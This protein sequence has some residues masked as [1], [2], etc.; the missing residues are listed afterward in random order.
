MLKINSLKAKSQ[1]SKK[2]IVTNV[3]I[4]ITERCSLKC[5][6]CSNLMQ[7]YHRPQNS[8]RDLL[9]KSVDK[10]MKCIDSLY[11]F[12]VLG[13]DPFMNKKMYEFVNKLAS[14]KNVHQV[15]IYT[16]ASILPKG[17]NFECL[18]QVQE[19]RRRK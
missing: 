7:Y 13:G 19:F 15:V 3:D 18:K 8:D 16:N 9:F 12:R 2:F 5:E 1:T 11:E 10:L 17:Q 6:S 4:V 14:Y